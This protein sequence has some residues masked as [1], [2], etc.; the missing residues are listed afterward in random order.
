MPRTQVTLLLALATGLL[1][2]P[3]TA[4]QAED[5]PP[6]SWEKGIVDLASADPAVRTAAARRLGAG[7]PQAALAAGVLV[8]VAN[9]DADPVVRSAAAAAVEALFTRA[10]EVW[11]GFLAEAKAGKHPAFLRLGSAL[12]DAPKAAP[13]EAVRLALSSAGP[14][15]SEA[16]ALAHTPLILMMGS[17]ASPRD[18]FDSLDLLLLHRALRAN[19]PTRAMAHAGLVVA[20]VTRLRDAGPGALALAAAS[21]AGTDALL[22]WMKDERAWMKRLVATLLSTVGRPTAAVVAALEEAQADR[23]LAR[24][25]PVAKASAPRLR[26]Q[27]TKGAFDS[28]LALARLGEREKLMAFDPDSIWTRLAAPVE[29]DEDAYVAP[30]VFMFYAF[31]VG[32][33][34]HLDPGLAREAAPALVVMAKTPARTGE[35]EFEVR[36]RRTGALRALGEVGGLDA[37]TVSVLESLLANEDEGVA[38][39]ARLALVR[40]APSA[41]PHA[42][43]LISRLHQGKLDSETALTAE[44]ALPGM[45]ASLAGLESELA[46][47]I[48]DGAVALTLRVA[49]ALA[50]GGMPG[51][52]SER[53]ARLRT[54]L[55]ESEFKQA[56]HALA[57]G[58]V[59]EPLRAGD[60]F[61]IVRRL[62]GRLSL[63][64]ALRSCGAVAAPAVPDLETLRK[65]ADPRLR[66]RVERALAAIRGK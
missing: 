28:G 33:M 48:A 19:E 57:T 51:C 40:G 7:Y 39:A 11:V 25:G 3:L 13:S 2:M 44:W 35:E 26:A 47:L 20:A 36:S 29:D 17:E 60:A 6:S 61:V 22:A 45:S 56:G 16:D 59:E 58:L 55:G 41:R 50:L 37:A 53:V 8:E 5:A 32:A 49:A 38:S 43:E 15:G 12:D 14:D 63:V 1:W 34:A 64:D 62:A 10:L 54:L 46:A 42:R 30:Y 18:E 21:D 52:N 27:L 4:A 66:W 31:Y 9:G 24:L 23:A 65:D